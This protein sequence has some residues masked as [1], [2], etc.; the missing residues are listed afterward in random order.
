MVTYIKLVSN[1]IYLRSEKMNKLIIFVTI[2]F[3]LLGSFCS[4][5][6]IYLKKGTTVKG[7]IIH[8]DSISITVDE[9]GSPRRYYNTQVER[10]ETDETSAQDT[11]VFDDNAYADIS[12][13]KVRLIKTL[14]EVSG[15]RKNIEN[16]ITKAIEESPEETR[17][18]I[19]SLVDIPQM[20]GEIIPVY[21]KYYSQDEIEELIAFYLSPL[22]QKVLDV[23]P[24]LM[25]EVMEVSVTYFKRKSNP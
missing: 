11:I 13:E 18:E 16:N 24:S 4:A 1:N 21:D 20:I 6:V 10:I 9:G 14:L 17:S 3:V 2:V 7:K 25:N 5:E 8:R 19:E 15:L 22:G 12:E 23:T